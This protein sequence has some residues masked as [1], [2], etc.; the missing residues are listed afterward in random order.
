MPVNNA[1]TD[2]CTDGLL[3]GVESGDLVLSVNISIERKSVGNFVRPPFDDQNFKTTM[4]FTVLFYRANTFNHAIKVIFH[5][6]VII[7]IIDNA[8]ANSLA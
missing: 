2:L 4:V 6:V 3:F 5:R 1:Y 7:S 8:S